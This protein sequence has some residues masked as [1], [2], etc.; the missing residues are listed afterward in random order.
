MPPAAVGT[1]ECRTV[2][3]HQSAGVLALSARLPQVHVMLRP[4]ER[5][6]DGRNNREQT[7][8]PGAVGAVS[9]APPHPPWINVGGNEGDVK[10]MPCVADRA[11]HMPTLMVGGRGT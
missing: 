2:Y 6:I 11:R 8:R 10:G 3:I 7:V 9:A 5:S 1:R 4:L